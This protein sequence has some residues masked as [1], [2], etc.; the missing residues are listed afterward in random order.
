MLFSLVLILLTGCVPGS[1]LG[2]IYPLKVPAR[3]DMGVINNPD[4]DLLVR[5]LK[6]QRVERTPV[7]LM[8]QVIELRTTHILY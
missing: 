4:S 6:G 3:P 5:A 8:R 7:W 2:N 1:G